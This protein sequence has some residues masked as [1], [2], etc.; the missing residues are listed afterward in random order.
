MGV[1]DTL[2]V[3]AA[4]GEPVPESVA[5]GERLPEGVGEGVGGG[6]PDALGVGSGV[7]VGEPMQL[8]SVMSPA[9]PLAP[10][11]AAGPKPWAK[12]LSARVGCV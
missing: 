9:A 2:G 10:A 7:G 12:T 3:A 4:E 11:T 6:E 1:G 8:T 5:V